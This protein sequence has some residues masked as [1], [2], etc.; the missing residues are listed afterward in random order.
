MG[1][2]VRLRNLFRT[3]ASAVNR[4]SPSLLK[5]ARSSLVKPSISLSVSMIDERASSSS[6]PLPPS[7]T[8]S[9][10]LIRLP[11]FAA[12]PLFFATFARADISRIPI[13][14]KPPLINFTSELPASG[15]VMAVSAAR[16]SATSGTCINPSIPTTSTGIP[17][18]RSAISISAICFFFRT[19][20]AVDSTY[21]SV[22]SLFACSFNSGIFARASLLQYGA[23]ASAIPSA[24]S[25]LEI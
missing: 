20:I 4:D 19:N 8:R 14:Q 24:S 10:R 7:M 11:P 16:I 12:K 1:R 18:A 2:W 3:L 9:T 23:M 6:S 21:R 5:S 15:L 17:R 25:R 13:R 22:A